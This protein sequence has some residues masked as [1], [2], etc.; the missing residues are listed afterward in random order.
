MLIL[1]DIE[2]VDEVVDGDRLSLIG[3]VPTLYKGAAGITED[4]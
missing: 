2:D 1:G 4:S 3:K